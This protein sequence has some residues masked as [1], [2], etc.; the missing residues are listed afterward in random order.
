MITFFLNKKLLVG[1]S[2]VFAALPGAALPLP[3][4]LIHL[5]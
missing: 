1:P 5:P 2:N 3:L 4:Y